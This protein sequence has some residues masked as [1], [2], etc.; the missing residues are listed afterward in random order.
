MNVFFIFKGMQF[1]WDGTKNVRNVQKHGLSFRR[2]CEVFFDPGMVT[3]PAHDDGGGE[4]QAAIGYP[5]QEH[6]LLYVV[7]LETQDDL[8][9]LVSAR[10]ATRN[11]R[12]IYEEGNE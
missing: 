10:P 6:G 8:I 1:T 4:I 11:E 12:K 7:Y 5:E 9:R 3:G 2:A